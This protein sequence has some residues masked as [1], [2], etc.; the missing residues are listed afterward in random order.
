MVYITGD[1]H[2]DPACLRERHLRRLKKGD[3]L[4]IC[5]DFGYIWDGSEAE[6]KRLEKWGAQ[7]FTVAFIDGVHENYDLLERYPLED[8]HGG[9]A[10]HITGDLWHLPR[11]EIYEIE[12]KR[13]FCMGGGEEPEREMR[14]AANTFWER[15]MPTEQEMQ[16]AVARLAA[17]DN[18]VDIMLTH[19]PSAK[20]G[21]QLIA[22]TRELNGV[23]LF[24]SMLEDTVSFSHWYFG[25]LHLDRDVSR[26]HTAVFRR[27]LPVPSD[28]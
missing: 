2:G 22:R 18:R 21:G 14:R 11:G 3:I 6:Q 19:E 9:Q 5:G 24:L 23:H 16:Q 17:A 26:N 27:V 8:W 15:E 25:A 13:Y 10:R 20:A 12:G 7:R 1:M 28:R 4:L